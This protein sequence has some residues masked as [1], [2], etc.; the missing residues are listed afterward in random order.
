MSRTIVAA[1]EPDDGWLSPEAV[2]DILGVAPDELSRL[3]DQGAMPVHRRGPV[4]RI[5]PAA[6]RQLLVERPEFIP[7]AS[8][9][10]ISRTRPPPV[11]GNGAGSTEGNATGA[12]LATTTAWVDILL[13]ADLHTAARAAGVDIGELA[14]VALSAELDRRA[15][16]SLSPRTVEPDPLTAGPDDLASSGPRPATGSAESDVP[17]T[18]HDDLCVDGPGASPAGSAGSSGPAADR[19]DPGAPG[20]EASPDASEDDTGPDLADDDPP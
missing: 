14:R 12:T 13:P 3:I 19:G 4:V 6:V 1:G 16:A 20:A 8:S 10:S 7:S 2:A 15:R 18:D 5:A 9:P 17:A 11:R